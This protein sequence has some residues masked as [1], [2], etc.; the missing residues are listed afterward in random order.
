MFGGLRSCGSEDI[1]VFVCHLTLIDHVIKRVKC[2]YEE[3]LLKAA[4]HT[5]KFGRNKHCDSE[6]IKV[7]VC[8]VISKYHVIKRSCG[9][10]GSSLSR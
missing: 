3:E 9:F 5:A 8:H 2:L 4:H 6:D 10:M 1:M 7:L